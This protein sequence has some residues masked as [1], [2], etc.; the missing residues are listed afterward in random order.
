[1]TS[2]LKRWFAF[3]SMALPELAG[4]SAAPMK[5]LDRLGLAALSAL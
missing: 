2:S 3:G 1:M 4:L 5:N